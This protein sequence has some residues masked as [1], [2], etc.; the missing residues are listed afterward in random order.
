MSFGQWGLWQGKMVIKGLVHGIWD[1]GEWGIG[2]CGLLKMESLP[3]KGPAY[4]NKHGFYFY[5]H[6]YFNIPVELVSGATDEKRRKKDVLHNKKYQ[7]IRQYKKKCFLQNYLVDCYIG[8]E[9]YIKNITRFS[10]HLFCFM[11]LVAKLNQQII[12]NRK[13]Y[14]MH[15]YIHCCLLI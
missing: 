6:R 5:T 9:G 12:F 10:Q 3:H 11:M 14:R 15:V 4:Y 13:K 7:T 8:M 2:Q 1:N